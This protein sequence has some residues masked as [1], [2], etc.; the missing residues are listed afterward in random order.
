MKYNQTNYEIHETKCINSVT[1]DSM[2]EKMYGPNVYEL[3][4]KE[5]VIE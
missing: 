3:E 5:K 1:S 2:Y 4:Y